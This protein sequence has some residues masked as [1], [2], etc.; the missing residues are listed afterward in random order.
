MFHTCC[1]A[2]IHLISFQLGI[3]YKPIATT[4][5]IV[6]TISFNCCWALFQLLN[7]WNLASSK[8]LSTCLLHTPFPSALQP[9]SKF[10]ISSETQ[11]LLTPT[12]WRLFTIFLNR[13][14]LHHN[15]KFLCLGLISNSFC[16]ISAMPKQSVTFF[17]RS[18]KWFRNDSHGVW[19]T[20]SAVPD[21]KL[22]ESSLVCFAC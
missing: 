5:R 21:Q 6:C 11:Y 19:Q 18:L 7:S 3:R 8:T 10:P 22:V 1:S 2:E 4:R 13:W 17:H 12:A 14:F 15:G 9:T 20:T 16:L